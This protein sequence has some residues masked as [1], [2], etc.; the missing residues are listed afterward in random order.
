MSLECGTTT[1]GKIYL[2]PE[3]RREEK[4][5]LKRHGTPAESNF[6]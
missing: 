2:S 6:S 5:T 3:V 4:K 1:V